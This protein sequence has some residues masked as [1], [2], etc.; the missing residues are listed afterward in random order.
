[1]TPSLLEHIKDNILEASYLEA[2]QR[3]ANSSE[4]TNPHRGCSASCEARED[5]ATAETRSLQVNSCD[6]NKQ[7]ALQRP[8]ARSPGASSRAR[9]GICC[10]RCGLDHQASRQSCASEGSLTSLNCPT[11]SMRLGCS[12]CEC[13]LRTRKDLAA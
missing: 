5:C 10:D 3:L 11:A 1:M 8:S 7:L 12:S 2:F 6:P 9:Q 13:S 4:T